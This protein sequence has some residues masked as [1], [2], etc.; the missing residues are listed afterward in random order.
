MAQW[1]R[2]E[3]RGW[4]ISVL[5][6]IQLGGVVTLGKS[7]SLSEPYFLLLKNVVLRRNNL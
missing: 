5:V 4:K 7:L 6:F 2:Y 1:E 3:I